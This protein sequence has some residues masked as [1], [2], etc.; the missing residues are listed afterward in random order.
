MVIQIGDS[1]RGFKCAVELVIQ[2][3]DPQC[4]LKLVIQIGGSIGISNW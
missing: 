4:L 3:G 2:I 1:N